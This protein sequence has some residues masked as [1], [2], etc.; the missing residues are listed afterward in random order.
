[1]ANMVEYPYCGRRFNI[2]YIN[3]HIRIA[4]GGGYYRAKWGG[5]GDEA[6][7]NEEAL[8]GAK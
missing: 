2:T 6:T 5:M 7:K 8:E 4:H 1:M 3:D